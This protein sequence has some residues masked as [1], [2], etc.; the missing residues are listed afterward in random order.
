MWPFFRIRYVQTGS[1]RGSYA[2]PAGDFFL[3]G[4]I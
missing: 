2:Q 1:L 3:R 4:M